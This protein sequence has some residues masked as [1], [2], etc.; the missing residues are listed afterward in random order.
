[1][2]REKTNCCRLNNKTLM[3]NS[4][5]SVK[6][7][8]QFKMMMMVDG[9]M[10]SETQRSEKHKQKIKC[11]EKAA[12]RKSKKSKLRF[13][14]QQQQPTATKQSTYST[15]DDDHHQ[16]DQPKTIASH[17]HNIQYFMYSN[18]WWC[19]LTSNKERENSFFLQFIRFLDRY[20]SFR[21]WTTYMYNST[22]KH[23]TQF[24]TANK[25]II[26]KSKI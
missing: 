8:F 1:M 25:I 7:N 23:K 24:T 11:R 15:H 18:G 2:K 19:R 17:H 6:N 26:R 20:F 13:K 9:Q 22:A 4:N 12:K 21:L 10:V 3:A 14:Q 5:N 16:T